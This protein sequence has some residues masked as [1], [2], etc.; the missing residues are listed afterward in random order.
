MNR[1]GLKRHWIVN[2]KS[3]RNEAAERLPDARL[4]KENKCPT[5]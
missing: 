4:P 5:Q 1:T 2:E 3:E